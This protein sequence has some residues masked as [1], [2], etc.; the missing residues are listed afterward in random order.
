MILLPIN[1]SKDFV[2][3]VSKGQKVTVGQIIAKAKDSSKD[4]IIHLGE[5][6]ILPKNLK[7]SLKKNLGD[8]IEIGDILAIKKKLFGKTKISSDVSGTISKI[9]EENCDVYIKT[10]VAV[11][12]Q[13]LISPVEG[14][15]EICNNEQIVLKTTKNAISV[16]DALGKDA[17]GSL[18][19][20][21]FSQGLSEEV[22][23][24]IIAGE[25]LDKV[26]LYKAIGLGAIGIIATDFTDLDFIEIQERNIDAA[27]V[28]VDKE[29]FKKLEKIN[30][31][32]VLCDVKGKAILVL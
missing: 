9:D 17:I 21:T 5:F 27:I 30:G 20:K 11:S 31:K 12:S 8:K 29:E 19:I 22:E 32:K 26:L 1:L 25:T 4:N 6:G 2:P 24:K 3:I 13:P 23:G 16:K 18:Y 7:V 15:V 10:E 28:L 14:I